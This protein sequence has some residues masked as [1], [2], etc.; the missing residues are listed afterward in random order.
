LKKNKKV[1]GLVHKCTM[2]LKLK[3][4]EFNKIVRY[5]HGVVLQV[6]LGLKLEQSSKTLTCHIVTCQ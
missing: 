3:M 4:Q 5:A 1:K 6:K 2:L